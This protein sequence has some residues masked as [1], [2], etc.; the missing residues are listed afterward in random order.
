LHFSRVFPWQ[1]ADFLQESGC[2]LV[3][4]DVGSLVVFLRITDDWVF[5]ILELV[6]QDLGFDALVFRMRG[7][8]FFKGCLVVDF[9]V[10]VGSGLFGF[11]CSS[12]VFLGLDA[13]FRILVWFFRIWILVSCRM[14][15]DWFFFGIWFFCFS[16]D[17]NYLVC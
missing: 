6:F 5:R 9:F 12:L 7:L 3:F 2:W 16:K 14:P 1:F 11:G 15:D 17:L 10:D 8:G 4:L 13:G